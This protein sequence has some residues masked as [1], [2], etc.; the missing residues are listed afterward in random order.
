MKITNNEVFAANNYIADLKLSK[1]DKDI[2]LALFKNMGELSQVV[3]QMQDKQEA[4]KK[5]VFEGLDDEAVKV[6]K[7]RQEFNSKETSNE[8]KAEIFKE[9][10]TY[11]KYFEAEKEYNEVVAN[12]GN[13]EIEVNIVAFDYDKFV[14]SLIAADIDFTTGNLNMVRFM[15]NE[16]K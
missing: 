12:F 5:K 6:N 10:L 3:K 8:R 2:R 11:Q 15:F 9:L 4:A 16:L 7:L 13:D 14:D 1:F